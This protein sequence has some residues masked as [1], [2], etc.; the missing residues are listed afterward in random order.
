MLGVVPGDDAP[1]V[2]AH[3][4]TEMEGSRLVPVRRHPLESVTDES[5]GPGRDLIVRIAVAPAQILG[6][7]GDHVQVLFREIANGTDRHPARIVE[8]GPRVLAAED[9][10]GEQDARHRAVRHSHA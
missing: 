8:T 5:A 3:G 10:I 1:Q 4:G 7:L 2:R 9:E 6:V